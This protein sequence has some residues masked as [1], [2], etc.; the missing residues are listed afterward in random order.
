VLEHR[1]WRLRWERHTEVSTWTIFVPVAGDAAP[2]PEA[3]ALDV[4]P[5]E[6]LAE[7]PGRVLVATHVSILAGE[8]ETLPF[9]EDDI[10]AADL[11]A[12]IARVFTDF[13]KG[14][15]GFTRFLLIPREDA[16]PVA[17][18]R[19]LQQILEI[20]SYRLLALLA[21]PLAGRTA[22]ELSVLEREVGEATSHAKDAASVENDRSLLALLAELLGRAEGLAGRTSFRFAASRAYYG[23]VLERIFQLGEA[24]VMTLPTLSEFMERRLAPA[25]RTCS[26][27]A[28]R[29]TGVINRLT[30]ATQML[31]TRVGVASEASNV[32]LLASMDRRS[33]LQLR[34]QQSVEGLSV[35][36]ISYY[37]LGIIHY[38]FK[39]ASAF[40]LHIDVEVAT[41][42]AA[43]LVIFAVWWLLRRT[44][45]LVDEGKNPH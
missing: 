45:A 19:I 10:V 8:P 38:A 16:A 27:V 39:A 1:N 31:S 11:G 14:P 23:I 21:F 17:I 32:E 40:A 26:A 3:T 2:D 20:E 34:L 25:M 30:R 44:H 4:L 36:A 42:I 5:E 7:M 15:D 43:P 18:G 9:E 29:Q 35:A 12:G 28:D 33:R 22:A 37:A 24:P 13:R 6:W 41:G